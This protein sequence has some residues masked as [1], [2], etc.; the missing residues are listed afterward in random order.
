MR[1]GGVVMV[2]TVSE[3]LTLS[4]R[5]LR[6]SFG[7]RVALD[8]VSFD[9]RPGRLT[10]FVGGNGAGKTTTMRAI[11]G[12][13]QPDAGEV[14][15]GGAAMTLGVRRTIGYMP[16]ERGL[17]P[18][19][20]V[21]EQ[22]VFLG[23]VLG[24]DKGAAA[25]RA[26]ELLEEFSLTDRAGD[27]LHT[28]SLGNQQRVQ[29]AAALIHNPKLLVLDEPFSGLDPTAM[30]TM[31][32]RL[33]ERAAAGLPVLFSSHQLDL[34]EKL[35]DD[36]VLIR[37]GRVVATGEVSALREQRAGRRYRVQVEGDPQ[38]RPALPG[39]TVRDAGVQGVTVELDDNV[40]PQQLLA[41]AQR[42]GAVGHFGR[43]L[44]SLA[45]LFAEVGR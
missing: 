21:L 45:E 42:A 20:K 2:V 28:L 11:V 17:Y 19:M 12:V 43:V 26:A 13:L 40:D 1:V 3:T 15:F 22:L 33:R 5:G 38:W 4:I 44:P 34:V 9:V 6:Q 14:T 32:T 30:D 7:D 18:K 23:R 39:V 35:C 29:I 10:G 36:I 31:G 16:E 25:Q 37:E 41:A 27:V 24:V 8:D